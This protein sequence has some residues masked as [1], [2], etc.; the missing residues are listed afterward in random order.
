MSAGLI[1]IS[2]G[3]FLL[4]GY[5]AHRVGARMH[6]PRVTLL[7]LIGVLAGPLGV[8]V[9]PEDVS[10]WFPV[11]S[12]MALSMVGFLLGERFVAHDIA[13]Y[14]RHV[15]V[16]SLGVTLLTVVLVT[17]A[18]LATGAPP[19]LALLLGSIATATAPAATLDIVRESR[20]RG[21]LSEIVLGVVAIDDAW[22]V[23]V[24][25]VLVA[26]VAGA[27]NGPMTGILDGLRETGMSMAI[28][29]AA[30]LP[31]AWLSGRLRA[32]EPHVAEAAGFVF[33]CAGLATLMEASYLLACMTQGAV[34]ANTA[35]H[36]RR[37][38]H[39][40]EG[41]AVPFLTLFFVLAGMR[42]EAVEMGAASLLVAAF[43]AGRVAGRVAGGWLGAR[44]SGAPDG[45][46][47]RVGWCL[48]PQAGVSVGLA[49]VALERAPALGDTVLRVVVVSTVLFEIVAPLVT[50]RQLAAAGEVPGDPGTGRQRSNR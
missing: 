31:M 38:F 36:H 20:A 6:V 41:V 11:V 47:A 45:V 34:V 2:L 14:G 33:L 12:A 7:L 26:V 43:V 37:P 13:R 8:G 4:A 44:A 50:R 40:I 27:G 46:G 48:L 3:A 49:L 10:A 9:V 35:R 32:G 15:I 42:L 16:V 29:V 19:S 28:G 23:M 39:T 25:S 5:V 1:L 30:G 21:P 24:F 18:V 22:G 17:G